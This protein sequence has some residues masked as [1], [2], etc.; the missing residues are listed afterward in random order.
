MRRH[1]A[2]SCRHRAAT[3]SRRRRAALAL[4][5]L[6][7]LL[8]AAA[9]PAPAAADILL[10]T[11]TRF[12][13]SAPE[14]VRRGRIWLDA[15]RI[16]LEFEDPSRPGASATVIFRGDRDLYWALDAEARAYVQIDR[17]EVSALGERVARA[18]REMT[19]RLDELPPEQRAAVE[20]MLQD[21]QPAEPADE[22]ER[23]V[24]TEVRGEID[25]LPAR[26]HRMM[27]GDVLAGEIW[28]TSWKH[29][30]ASRRDFRAFKQLASFQRELLASLGRSAGAAFGGEPFELFD[31][32]DGY[33]LRVRRVQ[34]GVLEAETRFALPR[35]VESDPARYAL[36]DGYERRS[37][38]G[39]G[40]PEREPG[41]G[42]S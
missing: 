34:R 18:R 26:L 8:A 37:G 20:Q 36:P 25:G 29:V 11:E 27:L 12:P 19:E 16:R 21:M 39:G 28:T 38:P 22:V 42:S 13:E 3:R 23:V 10:E 32:L 41:A 4:V 31:R 17:A 9:G 5:G 7:A 2:T 14:A 35:R 1:L 30:G 6:L 15:S 24:P 40:D 33:P